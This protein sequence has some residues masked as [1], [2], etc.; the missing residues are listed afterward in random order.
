MCCVLCFGT[1]PEKPLKT[2][3]KT[4]ADALV[5]GKPTQKASW[6]VLPTLRVCTDS[7]VSVTRA[8]RAMRYWE[9]LGYKF[10]GLVG[11]PFST[12]FN[13]KFGEIVITLPESGFKDVHMASTRIYTSKKSGD[14][15]K[16]KIFMLP[17]NAHKDRVLE[18]EIGHALGWSHYPQRY[19]IMHPTW[20]LGGWDSYGLH[21]R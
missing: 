15:V 14:I 18:H 16:A 13:A 21:K 17:N 11:D 19:H 8:A 9:R 7:G 3:T 20:R 10:D 12:C 5:I 2:S 1:H 6:Q 4:P